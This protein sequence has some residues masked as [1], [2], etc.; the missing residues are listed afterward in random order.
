VPLPLL[1]LLLLL[2]AGGA[3]ARRCSPYVCVYTPLPLPPQANASGMFVKRL[4]RDNVTEL[5]ALGI[6]THQLCIAGTGEADPAEAADG[7]RQRAWIA[8]GAT[9]VDSDV[10][11][12]IVRHAAPL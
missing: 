12:M 1:P 5:S 2:L 7:M 6:E 10:A 9:S 3:Q 8:H 11:L 4:L